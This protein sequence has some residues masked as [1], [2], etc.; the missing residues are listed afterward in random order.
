MITKRRGDKTQFLNNTVNLA[1]TWYADRAAAKNSPSRLSK[2]LLKIY[3][4]QSE[5]HNPFM[6]QHAPYPAR[7]S[8][9]P[10]DV[11]SQIAHVPCAP[12][13]PNGAGCDGCMTSERVHVRTSGRRGEDGVKDARAVRRRRRFRSRSAKS[14][15]SRVT[16][17]LC[18]DVA[19][20][21]SACRVAAPARPPRNHNCSFVQA[22]KFGD[23]QQQ[24]LVVLRNV[25]R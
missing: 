23:Q 8:Q 1:E 7:T 5:F 3:Q 15:R 19:I 6:H 11:P 17:N 24:Q 9:V 2:G 18:W 10:Y 12:N 25:R 13:L 20:S 16:A 21:A 14:I 22:S 4:M